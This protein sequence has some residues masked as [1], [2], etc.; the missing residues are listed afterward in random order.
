MKKVF[1]KTFAAIML[2]I[3]MV[4]ALFSGLFFVGHGEVAQA[5]GGAMD[6]KFE[7][8]NK[9][10]S[11]GKK[12]DVT[13]T[14]TPNIVNCNFSGLSLR[15]GALNPDKSGYDATMCSQLTISSPIIPLVDKPDIYGDWSD[16]CPININEDLALA[17]FDSSSSTWYNGSSAGNAL[18]SVS[19][20]TD[21]VPYSSD[22][23]IQFKF[24]ITIG[25]SVTDNTTFT[26]GISETNNNQIGYTNASTNAKQY[27]TADNTSDISV[28]PL[29]FTVREPKTDNNLSTIKAGQ[30]KTDS[31]LQDVTITDGS[32]DLEITIKDPTEPFYI[33]PTA[34]DAEGATITVKTSDTDTGTE[35]NSGEKIEI[36]IP[37]D[38]KISII[39]TAED[40]TSKTYTLNVTLVGAT[41]SALTATSD[42][43]VTGATEGVQETFDSQTLSYTVIVPSDATKMSITA[44]VSADNIA[45]NYAKTSLTLSKTGSCTVP[46]T[47]TSGTAFDV[48]GI[49]DGDTVTVMT[50]A[51]NGDG[52]RSNTSY[53]IKFEIKSVDT[54]ITLTVVGKT[55]SKTF[56]NNAEKA[57]EK[58]VDY[59]YIISGETNAAST[60][61]VAFPTTASVTLND[62]TY[63]ASKDLTAGTHTIVVTAEA[64]NTKTYTFILKA[65]T[66]LQLKSGVIAEFMCE[67]ITSTNAYGWSYTDKGLEHGKDDL[68]F[69]RYVIGHIKEKTSVNQFLANFETDVA[70]SL[71]L[72]NTDGTLIYNMGSPADGYSESDLNLT[73]KGVGTS[74]KLEYI[75]DGDVEETVYLSV[76]GDLNGDGMINT[77]DITEIGKI[78]NGA[79]AT[80]ANFDASKEVRLAAYL[81]GINAMFDGRPEINALDISA[82]V[83][84]IQGI[85]NIASFYD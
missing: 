49:A 42:T 25:S 40:G 19:S 54:A 7:T 18:L 82:L 27:Y 43:K 1:N 2:A 15:V 56:T 76:F 47:A 36:D 41:L 48:T 28:E 14:L 85:N 29:T 26:F 77:R 12:F 59:Y 57:T 63:M 51:D 11:K 35:V 68:D 44:T 4:L 9:V 83:E 6:I 52:T 60:V 53:V 55:T 84:H 81:T 22:N 69:D 66:P 23:T 73:N 75:V 16:L 5:D 8:D 46:S 74:W 31:E 62:V 30:G 21:S 70:N 64:G 13:V 10:F 39:V 61:T 78:I 71:K 58:A 67:E 80:I 38:G 45:N 17:G 20:T 37:T 79:S 34:S 32:T 33:L 3:V 65:Y 72:Y 50:L 24:A